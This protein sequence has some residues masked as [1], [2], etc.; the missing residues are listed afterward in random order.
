MQPNHS[1]LDVDFIY[2]LHR[3]DNLRLRHMPL[4]PNEAMDQRIDKA[5]F[6]T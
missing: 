5:L 2:I 6:T 4:S 1:V 3:F